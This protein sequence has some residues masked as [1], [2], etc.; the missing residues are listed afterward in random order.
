MVPLNIILGGKKVRF[1]LVS[2][3]R[4]KNIFKLTYLPTAI[5]VGRYHGLETYVVQKLYKVQNYLAHLG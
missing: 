5:G 3:G 4:L 2:Y 1:K